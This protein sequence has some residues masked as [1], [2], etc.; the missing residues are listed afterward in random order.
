[1]VKWIEWRFVYKLWWA[2]ITYWDQGWAG[3][4]PSVQETLIRSRSNFSGTSNFQNKQNS[5]FLVI[6]QWNEFSTKVCPKIMYALCVQ[7]HRILNTW[8]ILAQIL[9]INYLRNFSRLNWLCHFYDFFPENIPL[10]W[11]MS[12]KVEKSFFKN[13]YF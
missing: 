8:S 10:L 9:Y 4:V 2:F 6:W 12:K 13:V 1:M 3:K 11:K 7:K 5:H